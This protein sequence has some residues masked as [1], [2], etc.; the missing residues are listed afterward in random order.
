MAST[1]NRDKLGHTRF[2]IAG[3]DRGG[4]VAHRLFLDHPDKVERMMVLDIAP[5]LGA[6]E[7]MN[8]KSVRPFFLFPPFPLSSLFRLPPRSF[9]L[10]A[11]LNHHYLG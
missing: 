3:H 2:S 9:F 4:R 11:S 10:T 5:T 6:F 1:D 8:H 7:G